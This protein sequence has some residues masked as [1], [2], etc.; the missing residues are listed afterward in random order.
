MLVAA[1][2][3][4]Y[5]LKK[6]GLMFRKNRTYTNLTGWMMILPA[7]SFYAI[8]GLYPIVGG[9]Q[10]SFYQWDGAGEKTFIGLEYYLRVFQDRVVA[11]AFLNNVLY[12][13]GILLGGLF[14][15][16]LLAVTLT[17]NFRGRN[18]YKSIFF[19]PRILSQVIVAIVWGW[20]FNPLFGPLKFLGKALGID[21]FTRGWLGDPQLAL[22]ALMIAGSWTYFGFCMVIFLSGLSNVDVMLYDAA[23]IDGANSLQSFIYITIPQLRSVLT[24]II[25]YTVIDSFKVFDLV[26]IMTKGGPG[27]ATQIM[28]T[29]T[30]QKAFAESQVGYGAA[31]AVLLTIFLAALSITFIKIRERGD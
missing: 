6:E 1:I 28:A 7:L 29:Y 14:I 15:G 10:L 3:G 12:T 17:R 26:Y 8:F 23:K 16:L 2:P 19:M 25:L 4:V 22:P 31:I 9:I 21:L 5:T 30:Y 18:F 20:I 11:I 27:N 13:F 24:M